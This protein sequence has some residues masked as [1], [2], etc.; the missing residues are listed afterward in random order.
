MTG[1]WASVFIC[2][3]FQ[4]G[5]LLGVYATVRYYEHTSVADSLKTVRVVEVS[6]RS[7]DRELIRLDIATVG[8]RIGLSS[9][10]QEE[11]VQAVDSAAVRYGIPHLLL[12]AV[13]FI[14]SG[15]NPLAAHPEIRVR[16]KTTQAVG[17]MG[18]VWEYHAEKLQAEGIASTRMELTKPA[19]NLMASAC[20]L[21]GMM[22]DIIQDY[23]VSGRTLADTSVFREIV[24]RYYG[25]Y[26]DA[27]QQRMLARIK[28]TA[29]RQWMRR[30]AQDLLFTFR[31]D[32]ITTVVPL[33]T[34][35]EVQHASF[36]RDTLKGHSRLDVR[37]DHRTRRIALSVVAGKSTS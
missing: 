19:V 34:L 7:L 14:E 6:R 15:Y 8:A 11:Y 1:R 29:G 22:R 12:H 35:R 36:P 17:L 10:Q 18:I 28:D 32:T 24:R 23:A 30:V 16:G 20:I 2:V 9:G 37:G 21:R 3:A 25:A 5:V 27:Y 4:L 13:C 31:Q 33:D 26:N